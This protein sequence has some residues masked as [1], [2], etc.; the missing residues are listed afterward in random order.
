V[1]QR[2]ILGGDNRRREKALKVAR[3]VARRLREQDGKELWKEWWREWNEEHP[4]KYPKGW[5]YSSPHGFKQA[6]DRFL[7]PKHPK[8]RRPKWKRRDK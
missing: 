5:R 2:Q 8:Y 6:F 1:A 3:F 4:V 7:H